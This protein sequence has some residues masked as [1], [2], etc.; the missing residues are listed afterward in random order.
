LRQPDVDSRHAVR[1][2]RYLTPAPRS[3]S[4][5]GAASIRNEVVVIA[6]MATRMK[7]VP[8]TSTFEA[9]GAKKR[10][11]TLSDA[12]PSGGCHAAMAWRS[13]AGATS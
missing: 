6:D 13:R 8:D 11:R 4:A 5:S 2:R 7:T 10:A 9:I 1:D 12:R 3:G